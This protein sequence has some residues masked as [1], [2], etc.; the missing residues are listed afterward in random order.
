MG[1]TVYDRSHHHEATFSTVAQAELFDIDTVVM[2]DKVVA[3]KGAGMDSAFR[4]PAVT[5]LLR[6]PQDLSS[7][8]A[9][10]YKRSRKHLNFPIKIGRGSTFCA[11]H[12]L[13]S[14]RGRV[15]VTP[16]RVLL[17]REFTSY[18]V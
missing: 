16:Y 6:W 5:R 3:G 9:C 17:Y 4:Q 12:A 11:Y 15:S 13:T 18:K 2:P 7:L 14:P 8:L 10:A 1:A